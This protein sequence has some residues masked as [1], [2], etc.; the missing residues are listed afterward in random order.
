ME[1]VKIKLDS[2]AYMPTRA[3]K[4][5]AG[6]DLR[7]MERVVVYPR[8][9]ASIPTGVHVEIPEGYAGIL[10]S[11]SGLNVKY[12]LTSSGVIDCGYTGSI[13]CKIYNHGPD[14]HVFEKGDKI[15]QLVI[16]PVLIPELVEVGQFKDTER[17]DSGFGSSG[18]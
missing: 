12:N 16:V 11:K 9:F 4:D 3:H 5:D 1:K 13:V 17:G 15:S 6:M 10:K 18:K 7:S 8:S 2:G 14:P